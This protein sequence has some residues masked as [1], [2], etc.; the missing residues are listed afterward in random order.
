M[1]QANF[2]ILL[3]I[4]NH[5]TS[6]HQEYVHEIKMFLELLVIIKKRLL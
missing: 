1:Q 3:R 4:K 6:A 5:N 2:I